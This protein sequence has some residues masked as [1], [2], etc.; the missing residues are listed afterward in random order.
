MKKGSHHTEES[1]RRISA[2]KKGQVPWNTGKHRSEET[3]RKISEANMGQ[4]AWNKGIP[5][6]EENKRRQSET[7]KRKY[8]S[9]EIVHHMK[10]KH[11]SEETKRKISESLKGRSLPEETKRKIS[12]T[13]KRKYGT[14][15]LINP[16]KGRSHS[17]ETKRKLSKA[18]SGENNP[19]Y[20]RTPWKGKHHS[21]ET[22]R[23]MSLAGMGR[24]NFFVTGHSEESRRKISE[25]LMGHEVSD[26]TK[27]K[28]SERAKERWKDPEIRAMYMKSLA[29]RDMTGE[30]NHFYGKKH[31]DESLR[32]IMKSN[33]AKPNKAEI[34]LLDLLQQVNPSWRYVGDASLII[35]GKLPDF[36]DGD[37]RLC[38]HYG[39][40]WHAGDDPQDRIDF[41]KGFGYDTLVVWES[42]LSDPGAVLGRVESFG[43]F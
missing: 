25:G 40:Y 41:F 8:R 39:N 29:L 15:E 26:E 20:G 6:S 12:E 34:R 36:W 3:K 1:K 24:E 10:G 23:K 33:N 42:E 11:H 2:S 27:R 5:C 9:G 19:M 16:W 30:K 18:M 22:K 7:L 13:L 21:E 35:G 4:Q 17:E 28:L 31:S 38:E 14:G 32:K 43:V 37:K